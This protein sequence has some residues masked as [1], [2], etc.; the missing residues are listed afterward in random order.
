MTSREQVRE[1]LGQ[2]AHP[3]RH[4]Y[5]A[6]EQWP[7]GYW[8]RGGTTLDHSLSTV[9]VGRWFFVC[10]SRDDSE[11]NPRLWTPFPAKV[12]PRVPAED[13][14]IEQPFPVFY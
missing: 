12:S 11:R 1:R 7:K 2:L 5:S 3:A 9:P 6:P 8:N 4:R 14:L 10:W 13:V